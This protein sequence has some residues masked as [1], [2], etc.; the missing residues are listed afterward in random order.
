ME[1][2]TARKPDLIH[3]VF[4]SNFLR[5][6]RSLNKTDMIYM[7]SLAKLGLVK[8]HFPWIVYKE[9]TL[10]NIT[11]I[12]SELDTAENKLKSLSRKGLHED[13]ELVLNKISCQI[14]KTKPK[15]KDSV[16]KVWNEYIKETDSI[17]HPLREDYTAKI[18]EGYFSGLPP[19]K[20]LK[21]RE[22]IPDAYIF[23]SLKDLALIHPIHFLS[24]DEN[25]GATA[26]TISNITVH[27][28]FENF[29]NA[30]DF[31]YTKLYYEHKGKNELLLMKFIDLIPLVRKV[32]EN[33]VDLWEPFE[34]FVDYP[35]SNDDRISIGSI[36]DIKVSINKDKVKLIDGKFYVPLKITGEASIDFFMDRSLY[37]EID[38]D[39]KL[40]SVSDWNDHVYFAEDTD[41]IIFEHTIVIPASIL[42]E[43]DKDLLLDEL[44]LN[45]N[46]IEEFL[47]GRIMESRKETRKR[48]RHRDL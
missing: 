40:P 25:L 44:K 9:C 8:M 17:L 47:F 27:K 43:K 31:E 39:V 15:V 10:H 3:V 18:F 7:R 42:E 21:S 48:R 29:Y 33:E 6:D 28:T 22:D 20:K 34:A 24:K 36:D 23:E 16:E 45:P 30:N 32:I 46:D 11:D 35:L 41:N 5:T 2:S 12:T 37:Y 1:E 13:E 38:D 26:A 14:L 19:F 4:D